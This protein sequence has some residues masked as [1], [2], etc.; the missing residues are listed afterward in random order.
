MK[1]NPIEDNETKFLD[2][3][4]KHILDDELR[5]LEQQPI[6]KSSIK[7]R[8]QKKA[9]QEIGDS[10]SDSRSRSRHKETRFRI[11]SK[12]WFLTYPKLDIDKQELLDELKKKV[13]SKK[14]VLLR[15]VVCRELHKD[16]TPHMHAYIEIDKMYNCR[17]ARFWD[18]AG[19]HGDY[20]KCRNVFAAAKYIKKDGDVLEYGDISW[21]EKLN[22]KAEKRRERGLKMMESG[23]TMKEILEED[24]GL[25]LQADRVQKALYACKQAMIEPYKANDTRGVWIYGPPGVGKSMVVHEFEGENLFDKSQNKWWD[26][27]T[28]QSAV[29]IDDFD[30]KGVCLSHYLKKWTDRY[31]VTGEVKGA[32]V[33]LAYKV[34]YVT[35]N[36]H[37]DEI[38]PKVLDNANP[39]LNKAIKRRFMVINMTNIDQYYDVL[40]KLKEKRKRMDGI[41]KPVEKVLMDGAIKKSLENMEVSKKKHLDEI[42][43]AK[44]GW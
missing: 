26:G 17:D 29:L 14:R 5:K 35:S 8:I 21:A 37:I 36:Y 44:S 22:S 32:N 28:G 38:F 13:E 25:A 39:V 31:P 18:V 41:L 15:A 19:H 33:P 27:Y 34:F 1:I 3:A 20:A 11:Q 16:G 6:L 43:D 42:E 30:E 24:P 2:Q 12:S 4:T 7:K 10:S 9:I 40:S 23:T